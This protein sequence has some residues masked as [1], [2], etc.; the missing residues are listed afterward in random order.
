MRTEAIRED[1]TKMAANEILD[2][3]TCQGES[4]FENVEVD[5]NWGAETTTLWFE[6]FGVVIHGNDKMMV[7]SK[8]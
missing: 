6:D 1:I 5:Q 8:Y 3:F 2:T 4:R 7:G